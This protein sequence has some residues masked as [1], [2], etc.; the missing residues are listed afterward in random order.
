MKRPVYGGYRGMDKLSKLVK[1]L[2]TRERKAVK[3]FFRVQGM[4]DDNL[5]A[6]LFDLLLRK[7]VPDDKEAAR[8][9][10]KAEPDAAFS[11]LKKRLRKDIL[12]VM[13]WEEDAKSFTSDYQAAKYKARLLIL[14]AELLIHKGLSQFAEE[15]L[16]KALHITQKFELNAES[17]TVN[18]LLQAHIGLKKGLDSYNY[19]AS[20]NFENF[21]LIRDKFL[22]QDYFRKLTMP[23]LFFTN[24]E[25]NFLGKSK[26]A[27]ESLKALSEKSTSAEIR[28]WYLRSTIYYNHLINDYEQARIHAEEFLELIREN[29]VINA[30]DNLGGACM[31]LSIINLYLGQY[32]EAINYA[33]QSGGYFIAQS[34]NQVQSF[35]CLFGGY[36]YSGRYEEAA[37]TIDTVLHFKVMQKNTFL[38]SRWAY[39]K[40]NLLF[41]KGEF[42][43]AL[44][45]L[46]QESALLADKS[47]WR[48]G[49]KILEMMCIIEIGYFDWLDYRIETFR[50]LL[51]DVKKENISR[52]KLIHQLLKSYIKTSYDFDASTRMVHE[53]LELLQEGADEFRWDPKGYEMI[54]FD[55]WWASKLKPV[56]AE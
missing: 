52:P 47:G 38:Q 28:Y 18:D 37:E 45:I 1:A 7:E 27:T 15:L 16:Q 39:Y 46:Q 10:Y 9:L 6:R 42:E 8:I 23:N 12:K 5:K 51:S 56:T 2:N 49:Y 35:D 54:R 33:N 22:A 40:A 29:P 3:K 13:V 21:E 34:M 36:F 41:R 24:K 19:F 55:T 31:Q 30:N 20:N 25:L 53:H 14:E 48:L 50:K 32:G 4:S 43:D 17:I 11:M 44:G 26:E